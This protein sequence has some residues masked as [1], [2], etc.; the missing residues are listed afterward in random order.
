MIQHKK[1]KLSRLWNHFKNYLFIIIPIIFVVVTILIHFSIGKF[2]L[3]STDPEYLH[4]LNGINLSIFNLSVS[5]IDHPG[6]TIQGIY[7]ISAHIVNIIQPSNNIITNVINHP[8]DFIHGASILLILITCLTIVLFGFYTYKYTGNML[9]AILVQLIPFGNVRVLLVSGRLIPEA[10]LIGP[11]IILC[12]LIIKFIYD[13]NRENNIKKYL[14]GFAIAGGLGMA[15]KLN[16]LPFLIIPLFL[17]AS[18][19]NRLKYLFYTVLAT[20]IFAFPLVVNLRKSWT[21]YSNLFIHSGKW[22]GGESNFIDFVNIPDHLQK[23]FHMDQSL[24]Y[25]IGFAIVQIILFYILP[26]LRRR[27]SSKYLLKAMVAV[28]VALLFSALLVAKHF[29]FHYFVPSLVFKAFIIFLSA[30]LIIDLTNRK[31]TRNYI[32]A[33]ALLLMLFLI[34]PQVSDLKAAVAKNKQ[35]AEKFETRSNLL[36][37][38]DVQNNPLIITSNYRGSPFIQSALVDGFL[39]SGHLKSTYIEQLT[40]K[41]PNTF[42]YFSWSEHFYFWDQ[43]LNAADFVNPD[44]PVYLFIGE[45]KSENLTHIL[46]RIEI[47]FADFDQDLKLLNQFTEPEESFYEL[48]FTK[49]NAVPNH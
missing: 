1:Y 17:I 20:L 16:Y 11:L 36:M 48:T 2:Y 14:V 27:E 42:F 37:Q 32:S 47:A 29:A 6:T 38:Y 35:R 28:V 7:A 21:W 30:S 43:F 46:K 23:I 31:K 10:A 24:F 9:L 44:R 15:G 45:D 5:Y 34:I 8:E 33:F 40:E 3:V 26:F 12:L 25:L 49:R 19:K 18:A 4:L 41:Y 39:Q 13:S 22:G